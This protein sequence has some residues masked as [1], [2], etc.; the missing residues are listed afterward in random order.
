MGFFENITRLL[1]TFLIICLLFNYKFVA[2]D[3]L[4]RNTEH[5]VVSSNCLIITL[6][7]LIFCILFCFEKNLF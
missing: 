6:F 4:E 7:K 3:P 1:K 2:A 5:A